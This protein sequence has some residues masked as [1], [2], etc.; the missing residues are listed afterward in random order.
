MVWGGVLYYQQGT[1]G[2]GTHQHG[3]HTSTTAQEIILGTVTYQP[4]QLGQSCVGRAGVVWWWVREALSLSLSL[5]CSLP[6]LYV[7]EKRKLWVIVLL[8]NLGKC[9]LRSSILQFM[10]LV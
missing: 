1:G 6:A 9:E 10:V 3:S 4:A 2:L 8:D 5:T 7:G